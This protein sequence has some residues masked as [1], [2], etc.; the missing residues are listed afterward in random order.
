M[1]YSIVLLLG[2][3]NKEIPSTTLFVSI[4]FPLILL[5]MLLELR[6]IA[7]SP[8]PPIVILLL[9]MLLLFAEDKTIP[10]KESP[11]IFKRLFRYFISL[12]NYYI[13][14]FKYYIS[15]L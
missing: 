3:E 13:S 5:K 12:I 2:P 10:P 4:V 14:L 1:L 11:S 9:V 15:K 8:V 6:K 7:P